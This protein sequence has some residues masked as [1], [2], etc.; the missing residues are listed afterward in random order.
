M[1]SVAVFKV[2]PEYL[3]LSSTY[4]WPQADF[5]VLDFKKGKYSSITYVGIDIAKLNHYTAVL[6]YDGNV[7]TEQFKFLNDGDGCKMLSSELFDYAPENMIIVLESTATTLSV[8]LLPTTT[9]Y[10]YST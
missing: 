3:S 4:G 9:M 10:V 5:T 6:S 1:L 7:L 2:D 8:T